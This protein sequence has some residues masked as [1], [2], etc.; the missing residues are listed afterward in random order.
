[1]GYVAFFAIAVVAIGSALGLIVKKN[2][3][4]G[5]WPSML[6]TDFA[7]IASWFDKHLQPQATAQA[8]N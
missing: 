3:G 8:G 6:T 1:M 4:H 7:T 2:A 5:L